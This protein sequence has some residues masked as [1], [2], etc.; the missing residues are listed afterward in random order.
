MEIIYLYS[1]ENKSFVQQWKC[2]ICTAMEINYLYRNGNELTHCSLTKIIVLFFNIPSFFMDEQTNIFFV[3]K[4]K[5]QY[6]K[7]MHVFVSNFFILITCP[8][9]TKFSGDLY[10]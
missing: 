6:L 5:F 3:L 8:K 4:I 1:N 9:I 7:F 10:Y 2:T